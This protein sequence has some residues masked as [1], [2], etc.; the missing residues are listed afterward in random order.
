[1]KTLRNFLLLG[2]VSTLIDYAVYS[3]MLL[4]GVYYI[5]AIILGYV[6]G[7]IANF[8]G[9]RLF[10]FTAGSKV[11]KFRVELGAVFVIAVIGLLINIGIVKLLSYS[12]M[13]LDPYLSRLVGIGIAFFWNYA[14]RKL[15]VYH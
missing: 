3:L 4:V 11:K 1:M 7:F 14:A 9:G 5:Y 6:S 2:V 8:Y 15:F 13:E 10:I 12:W